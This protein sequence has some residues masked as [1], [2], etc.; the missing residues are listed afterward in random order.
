MRIIPVQW[1]VPYSFYPC[2]RRLS[3]EPANSG[4]FRNHSGYVPERIY[5][6]PGNEWG[7]LPEWSSSWSR[8]L[9]QPDKAKFWPKRWPWHSQIQLKLHVTRKR[10][11]NSSPFVPLNMIIWLII[12]V[13]VGICFCP[14]LGGR[15]LHFRSRIV[16]GTILIGSLVFEIAAPRCSRNSYGTN[17]NLRVQEELIK[18]WQGSQDAWFCSAKFLWELFSNSTFNLLRDLGDIILS[19]FWV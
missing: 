18:L 19:E 13:D 15:E 1:H 16:W 10:I 17:P 2:K 12:K 11:S 6:E 7:R 8:H 9:W 3:H 4:P 14:K 5:Y